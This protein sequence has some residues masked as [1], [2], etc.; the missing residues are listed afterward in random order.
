MRF[1]A[2]AIF[3]FGSI[4]ADYLDIA[5]PAKGPWFTGPL[6]TPSA[7][8]IP[9]GH[10]GFQPYLLVDNI[11]SVFNEHWHSVRLPKTD[12]SISF[13]FLA[14]F[15]LSSFMDLTIAPSFFYNYVG[16]ESSWR[17]GDLYTEIA[18]QL[19]AQSTLKGFS[20]KFAIG[21][22][23]PTGVYQ[24]LNPSLLGTDASGDGSFTTT[25]KLVL[26]KRWNPYSIHYLQATIST[27]CW[28]SS[29]VDVYGLNSYGGG[30]ST[31]GRVLPG[32][33]FPFLLGFEYNLTQNW[34]LAL[35]VAN[36]IK[37][38]TRFK[39]YTEH[40]VGLGFAY[41]LSLAP[42]IEYNFSDDIG[43]IGGV[44][45]SCKGLRRPDHFNYVISLNWYH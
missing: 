14:K 37:L 2:L 21:E 45:F 15:G 24:H 43:L 7:Y 35:D 36:S 4:F 26:S 30:A 23:F 25:L 41:A 6:L 16:E 34:V 40:P 10:F 28:L 11:P 12:S 32:F 29:K 22:I 38:K 3:G 17:F 1:L 18:F 20:A 19:A 39:G 9:K 13:R 31:A 44:W 42:A 8:T 5:K 33:Y 27:A